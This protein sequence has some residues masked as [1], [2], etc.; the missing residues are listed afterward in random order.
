M[1]SRKSNLNETPRPDGLRETIF[2]AIYE[3]KVFFSLFN[4]NFQLETD[5]GIEFAAPSN[6]PLNVEFAT[7]AIQSDDIVTSTPILQGG[8]S[9]RDVSTVKKT[10]ELKVSFVGES[11]K[12]YQLLDFANN[13]NGRLTI[14]RNC[15]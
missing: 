15:R 6:D 4:P 8:T 9:L 5:V 3:K 1:A 10:N 11:Q 2:N 12:V 13:E 14:G 7:P